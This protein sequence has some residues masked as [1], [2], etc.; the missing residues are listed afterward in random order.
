M[1]VQGTGGVS[2]FALQ[3]AKM[4]GARVIV[5]SSSDESWRAP[6]CCRRGRDDHYK[7]NPE[8]AKAALD[9]TG[10]AGVDH[11]VEVGGRY[12]QP[13]ARGGEGRRPNSPSACC[14]ASR[15]RSPCRR[16]SARTCA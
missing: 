14:P 2:I 3:F 4:Q 8:W 12:A 10:G 16:C 6:R 1:L 15:S 13:V 9:L 5:T 7:S 11:V